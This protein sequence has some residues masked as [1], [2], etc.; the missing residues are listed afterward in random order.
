MPC[1][2]E[3]GA[4]G[5]DVVAGFER[6]I[7]GLH[8]HGISGEVF[9]V[10]V[11][12]V[13]LFFEACQ[14]ALGCPAAGLVHHVFFCS[15]QFDVAQ[16]LQVGCAVGCAHIGAVEDQ[17]PAHGP[18]VDVIDALQISADD[19]MFILVPAVVGAVVHLP[20]QVVAAEGTVAA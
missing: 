5:F 13:D 14:F 9:V 1:G 17:M 15:L 8:S 3:L 20:A 18:Q 10:V 6:D 12:G 4:V 2:V 16:R 7:A 11:G 19:V